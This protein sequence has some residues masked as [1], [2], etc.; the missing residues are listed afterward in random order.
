MRHAIR[1]LALTAALAALTPLAVAGPRMGGGAMGGMGG[2]HPMA[3]PMSPRT[4]PTTTSSTNTFR[5]TSKTMQANGQPNQSCQAGS[6]Y[7]A[8]TPGNSYNAPGSAF[9]PTGVADGKYA[10]T[11]PQNSKNPTSV[12]QYDVACT[13]QK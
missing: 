7:P 12:S 4:S 3:S 1:M 6:N 11:Q 8:N 9:D 5:S 10:G 13:H 2:F